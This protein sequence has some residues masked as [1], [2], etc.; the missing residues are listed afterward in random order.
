M[1]M[2]KPYKALYSLFLIILLLSGCQIRNLRNNLELVSLVDPF[3]GTGGHGHVFPGATTPF[4]M[5]QLSP[6]NGTGGWDWVSGYHHSS[7]EIVG[8]THMQLS[9]TGIGDLCDI[10]V[11]PAIQPIVSDSSYQ[12]ADFMDP[13]KSTFSHQK[14]SASPG[15]YSVYLEDPGILAELTATPHAG[16]HSYTF[17]ESNEAS[18]IMDLGFAINWDKALETYI[19]RAGEDLITGYRYSTGWATDQKVYFALRT[20]KPFERFHTIKEWEM[21][22]ASTVKAPGAKA[23]MGFSTGKDEKILVKVGLSSASIEG[24]IRSLDEELPGWDFDEV[25][26]KTAAVWETE[27][28][29]IKV[30]STDTAVLK[31]FYTALYHTMIA[32]NL[33][34]DLNGEYK[35]LNNQINK[36]GTFD[37][38][39]VFSLW[40]TFR[41]NHPL[42]TITQP[43]KVQSFVQSFMAIYH[44]GGLLPVWELVGNET[45]TM[46]GYHAIP[47]ITDAWLKGLLPDMNGLELLEAM[48]TSATQNKGGIDYYREFGFIPSDLENESVSKTL[49]Y[50]YDDWCIAQMAKS[51]NNQVVYNLF[52]ERSKNYQNLFDAHTGFMRGKLSS[53]KWKV[54]FDPLYSK[55]RDDDYTEGN[56][57]QYT[58]F[59]PQDPQGLIDLYG[60]SS[61]FITKLDSLFSI[62]QG[63]KGEHASPDI[64]G[65]IGQYA[66]G[67]EPSH[68]VAYF[69]N[70]AGQPWKT[71][72]K[73]RQ[74][75]S[76]LYSDQP[77]G[78]SGNE[79][80]GQMSAWYVFS[81]MGFYPFNPASG[82]YQ[83]GS[84]LFDTIEIALPDK[85]RFSIETINNSETNLYIQKVTL[86]GE[87]LTGTSLR[88]SDLIQGGE[89][90]ITMG[91]T[92]NLSWPAKE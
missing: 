38:Y 29:K 13:Y 78:L 14:E 54:P 1:K 59:V 45:N 80:C 46:I 50:A 77:D 70:L 37:R 84:P 55:H 83:L 85:K 82:E 72:E 27:L 60:G 4:G 41:A 3:I 49:E 89:M 48:I 11:M 44:E 81:A 74:I 25:R 87:T 90:K 75:M 92:P 22:T 52:L 8:F 91:D 42:F 47:V 88:H 26:H 73:V 86:N 5:V 62:S 67:N 34:S 68:H 76:T 21:D 19:E 10:L 17:P 28:Q 32:P 43:Q 36:A 58:W 12:G 35:G 33:H 66:H 16:F 56:A 40:D 61:A 63:L 57:W 39:T 20:S 7:S 71:Q 23:V 30:E 18:L 69:Y 15:Y 53:G 9:G 6:N 2:Q 79:D 65:L 31:T 64:S 24:A 51:L